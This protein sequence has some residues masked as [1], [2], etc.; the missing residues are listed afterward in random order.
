MTPYYQDSAV[1][2]Y[3]GE[4]LDAMSTLGVGAVDAVITDPPYCAGGI[5]ESSR[6]AAAGQ[7]LRSENLKRFGWFVGDNM[8][9]AGLTFLLRSVAYEAQRVTK[10]TGSL[11]VFCDWRMLPTLAPAIESSGVRYQG[12]VVWDK[13]VLG[14]GTGFRN[15]HELAMHFTLGAPEYHDKGTPNVLRVP[16]VSLDEREHQTQKPVPLLERITH[17]V[18]PPGG[19][20]L[21]PFAGSGTTLIAAKNLGRHCIGIERDEANCEV[22]AQRLSQSVLDLGG[23]A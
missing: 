14:M 23:A 18:C 16:R 22:A 4:A 15:Q 21:D 2:L 5:S 13:G 12:L 19:I 11:I 6:V 3:H 17:V 9:T 20:T 10:S 1:T 7:G 8:G